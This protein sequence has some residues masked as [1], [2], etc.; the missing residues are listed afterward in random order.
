[1]S[2]HVSVIASTLVLFAAAT[3]QGFAQTQGGT[4]ADRRP[5]PYPVTVP[6]NFQQAVERGTR[7]PTGEPGP[8]YWQQWADYTI[9]ARL[10]T[11][12]KRIDGT[13]RIVYYNRSPQPLPIVWLHLLQ[14]VHKEGAMRSRPQETTPGMEI[15]RVVAQ[16]E[17][18]EPG[19]PRSRAGYLEFGTTLGLRLSRPVASGESL[20]IEIDW[21]FA[22]PQRGSGR[23]GWSR[24]NLFYIAYWYP[25]MAVYDDVVGW[26]RDQFLGNAEFYMG[27]GNYD[28]TVEAPEGWLVRATGRLVNAE[29]VL[30]DPI[31]QRLRR[32]EESDTVV[33]LITAEDFGPGK[34]TRRSETGYLSWHFIADSVRDVAFS[35]TSES[36]WDAARIPLG[37]RDGDGQ[38]DYARADAIY[39][40][41][42]PRWQHAWRYVQHSIDFLSRWTSYSYPWP[43]MT[44]VEGADIIG[45]GMEFP[46]MTI[47][48]DYSQSS[49]TGLYGVTA[50]EL[51]HMW[52]P[53]I[54][55]TD[56]RRRSWMDE[57]TT[58][59]NGSQAMKEFYPGRNWDIG[60]RGGYL[61][62][63]R[64]GLEGEIMRWSDFHYAGP[65]YGIASYA[66][67]ATLLATLRGL[68]GEETFVQAFRKYIGNW[69]F[70]HPKPWDFFN[71]FNSVSG[72]NLDW[73]WRA[74]YYET[75]TLDHAV[76]EVT[77]GNG[78]TRI[79]VEDRGLAPM[80]ARLTITLAN[81]DI[82]FREVPVDVWLS[83]SWTAEVVVRTDSPV[84]R[85]VIDAD[86]VF[87]DVD[88]E[89]NVWSQ[90]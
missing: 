14:N 57:G 46:M 28:L 74:W 21:G 49:D 50:H 71:T 61:Q 62:V 63:A 22:V 35:A 51:A 4:T 7:S 2:R 27:Y 11:E 8:T 16:G 29:E 20:E 25:Q 76:A 80:P 84:V 72:Q 77:V 33:H 79:V 37:D 78:G 23:M 42:A 88:R 56:E 10:D 15:K 52:V 58:S 18:L 45:G 5:I 86:S 69:A 81:G 32:A 65:A 70:K 12:A 38:T 39:R 26:Q 85:V 83:G 44:A 66:K 3:S 87:P 30:P 34:A 60:N 1:M 47:M 67:P 59:F 13:V 17:E 75:W 90:S 55:G 9:N 31:L 36:L 6:S 48:G 19:S 53:M 54:V 89:N 68:L 82:L 40:E 41:T 64:A 43:H 73:F 24:D